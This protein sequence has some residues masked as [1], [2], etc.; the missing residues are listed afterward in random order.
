MRMLLLPGG[1]RAQVLPEP[2]VV[3]A[4]GEAPGGVRMATRAARAGRM[5]AHDSTAGAGIH[6]C[7]GG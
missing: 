1:C 6:A 5:A 4:L 7:A 2:A 3:G